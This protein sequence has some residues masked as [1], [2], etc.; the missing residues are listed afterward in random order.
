MAAPIIKANYDELA[1]IMQEFYSQA[2]ASYNTLQ[3]VGATFSSLAEGGWIGEGAGNFFREMTDDIFPAMQRLVEALSTSS[4]ATRRI[5]TIFAE[6]EEEAGRLFSGQGG[7]GGPF[8]DSPFGG[9]LFGN[10]PAGIAALGGIAAAL[11]IN[12][13]SP[14]WKSLTITPLKMFKNYLGSDPTE[15]K[16]IRDGKEVTL[17]REFKFGSEKDKSTAFTKRGLFGQALD[18]NTKDDKSFIN[19]NIEAKILLAGDKLWEENGAVLK[20]QGEFQSGDLKAR[21]SISALSYDTAGKWEASIGKDGLK[22]GAS[23][24]AGAYLAQVQGSAEYGGLQAAGN[25][26]IGAQLQGEAG[27]TMR[28]GQYVA[29]AGAEGFA[30]GKAEGQV[31]YNVDGVGSAGVG[32]YVSYGIGAQAEV[33]AGF[34]DGKFKFGGKLGA[35]LG[36]GAGIKFDVTIDARGIVNNAVEFGQDV[37]NTVM[38]AGS[39]VADFGRSAIDGIGSWFD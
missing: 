38:D 31:K 21:G 32:G 11:G 20:G 14:A 27:L 35:T 33:K 23:G 12:P 6:A 5:G 28:P 13:N 22:V 25:A 24:Y 29:T 2:E 4:E 36:V 37:G 26:Y 8:G 19:K 16:V 18:P 1:Q 34:D 17:K 3:A 15:Y 10:G 39:K 9:G 30:G 7:A